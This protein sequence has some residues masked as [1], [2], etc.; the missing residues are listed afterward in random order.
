MFIV[1]I[2][3]ILFFSSCR[4][5]D[6]IAPVP[7]DENYWLQK[8]RGV[9]VYTDFSCDYY[10]VETRAGYSVLKTTGGFVPYN[11]DVLYGDLNRWS[12]GEIYNRSTG[13]LIRAKVIEYWLSW[14]GARDIVVYQCGR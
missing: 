5:G 8:D 13:R 7:I 11:G 2:M 14:F 12:Y 3:S 4:K 9:V 1:A 6:I 10:I